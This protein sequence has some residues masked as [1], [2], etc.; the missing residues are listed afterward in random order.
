M[1]AQ[2]RW[3]EVTNVKW[4][5]FQAIFT[6]A[7]YYNF[8]KPLLLIRPFAVILI[9]SNKGFRPSYADNVRVRNLTL[10]NHGRRLHVAIKPDHDLW[11]GAVYRRKLRRVHSIKEN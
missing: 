10:H 2:A 4:Y 5:V 3:C 11:D 6:K 1:E 7:S 8:A 9:R